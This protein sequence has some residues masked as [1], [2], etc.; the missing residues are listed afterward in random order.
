M[1]VDITDVTT[2]AVNGT[3][4]FD[5][6]MEAVNAQ[7]S[8]QFSAQRIQKSDYAT[9]YLNAIQVALTQAIQFTVVVEQVASSEAKTIND[10]NV[11]AEQVTAS[12]ANTVRSDLLNTSQIIKMTAEET[13]IDKKALT[14]DAQ[15]ALYNQKVL[16]EEAQI[17]DIVAGVAVAGSVGTQNALRVSQGTAFKR[18]SEQRA[19]KIVADVFSVAKS[20]EP[21][22]DNPTQAEFAAL[23]I[24][25]TSLLT[26]AFAP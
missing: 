6:I 23:N 10:T 7:L 22:I 13:L 9:V 5:K 16:T 11:A 19:V 8:A 4:Y 25:L 17:K 12:L 15:I 18:S 24:T 21:G 2:G 1:P 3:G 14:E 26:N 20:A